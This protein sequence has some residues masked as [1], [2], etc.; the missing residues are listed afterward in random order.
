M[1]INME[2][3]LFPL[4]LPLQILNAFFTFLIKEMGH[5]E[6]ERLILSLISIFDKIS[7]MSL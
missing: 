6:K 1:N 3:K 5:R 4:M 2:D 7:I